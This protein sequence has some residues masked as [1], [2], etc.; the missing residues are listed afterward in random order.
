MSAQSFVVTT[1]SAL[2]GL[3]TLLPVALVFVVA[4]LLLGLGVFAHALREIMR[5]QRESLLA[6]EGLADA[7]TLVT[8][9]LRDVVACGGE[10]RVAAIAAEHIDANAAAGRGLA[11]VTARCTLA[12]GIGG[13][14]PVLLLLTSADWLT[15]RGASTGVLLGAITYILQA[16]QPALQTL[17]SSFG[18]NALWLTASLGRLVEANRGS[19]VARPATSARPDGFRIEV[20]D[21]DFAY[22]ASE[23]RVLSGFDLMLEE[24]TH[25]AV[26]GPSGIGKSTLAALLAG[27]LSPDRG[28][29]FIG[30]A[31]TNTIQGVDL[32][33]SCLLV[34]Q[35]AYVFAGT[36][37]A[38][39]RY[40][41]PTPPVTAQSTAPTG[42][43]V[44]RVLDELGM[45]P[46]VERLGGLAAEIDPRALSAGERQ[47]ITLARAYLS[48]AP[49]VILDEATC[50][51]DALSE[52]RVEEAFARR[53]G[54][55]V[56]V[57]HRIS[58]AL[59]AKQ[60]LLM[61]AGQPVVGSH[62]ELLSRSA[63][64]RDLTGHWDWSTQAL[65]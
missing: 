45:W 33:R 41:R 52:A 18:G 44:T 20:R 62:E 32:V 7:A 50:H 9:G 63:L 60:V 64:Y 43:L 46:L 17:V 8:D 55:L 28:A 27:L 58:S 1:V 10:Q 21:V 48:P 57:A 26:V 5:R 51:L 24:G 65:G 37:A 47:L 31:P 36:L 29:V 61:D 25:L 42:R 3:L 2:L 11:R 13:W 22:G 4:P 40:L 6:E 59:R 19:E 56:V 14:L 15:S 30:G 12:L 39:I 38:N 16:L 23:Q 35:Q 53:P 54:T 34:P 49:V